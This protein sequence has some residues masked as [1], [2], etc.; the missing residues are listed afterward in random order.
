ML[1]TRT[2]AYRAMS[3]RRLTTDCLGSVTIA[4]LLATGCRPPTTIA[5]RTQPDSVW[6]DHVHVISPATGA[7]DRDRALLIVDGVIKAS[8]AVR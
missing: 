8:V 2:E 5:S 3:Q 6:V 7:V 1:T 4:L